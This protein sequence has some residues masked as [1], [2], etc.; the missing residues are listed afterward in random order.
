[1]EQLSLIITLV[2]ALIT[3]A[4]AIWQVRTQRVRQVEDVYVARYW[5][6][7]DRLSPHTLRGLDGHVLREEEE[8]AIRLYFRLSE[9][10]ANLRAQG[11]VSDDT[12]RDWS[13]AITSQMGRPPFDLLWTETCEDSAAGRDYAFTHLRQLSRNA[14]YDPT[15]TS[16]M[17]RWSRRAPGRGQRDGAS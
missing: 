9:D 17:R 16:L 2:V 13:G 5:S 6:L 7:L 4:I 11:W 12:W 14:D 10:Q 15:P 3:S 8:L 1:M